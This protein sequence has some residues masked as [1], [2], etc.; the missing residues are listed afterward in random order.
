MNFYRVKLKNKREI[1]DST[2]AFYFEKPEGFDFLP[3]QYVDIKLN[4]EGRDLSIASSPNEPEI[5]IVT[6]MRESAFKNFLREATIGAEFN[7]KGPSGSFVLPE[8]SERTVVL[9]AGGIGVTPFRSMV[10]HATE[11]DLPHRIFLFHSNRRPEDAP[12][13]EELN[14]LQLTTNNFK[15]IPTMTKSDWNGE[16]GYIDIAM[17]KKYLDKPKEAIYYI[18]GPPQMVS[19]VWQALKLGGVSQDNI[20]TEEFAGY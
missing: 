6:R 1:A 9:I 5:M 2:Y 10:K 19:G 14:D 13:L 12:F 11:K 20:R 16:K 18:A 7:L 17:I 8:S 3:G 15:Y 4:S